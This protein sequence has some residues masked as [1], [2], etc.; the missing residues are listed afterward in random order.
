MANENVPGLGGAVEGA[1]LRRLAWKFLSSWGDWSSEELCADAL[2]MVRERGGPAVVVYVND[3]EVETLTDEM[4]ERV[5]QVL[6]AAAQLARKR[7]LDWRCSVSKA[8]GFSC[9]DCRAWVGGAVIRFGSC[10][11]Y[12]LGRSGIKGQCVS[13]SSVVSV[14]L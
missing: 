3:K 7:K 9:S 13:A 10:T 14:Y 6:E 5:R 4:Y 2:K 12:F 8:L 1:E 11:F